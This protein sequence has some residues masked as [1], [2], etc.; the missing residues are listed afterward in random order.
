MAD[1]YPKQLV[2]VADGTVNPPNMADAR[3]VFALTQTSIYSKVT[4]TEWAINDRVCLGRKPAG[5]KIADIAVNTGTSFGSA[6][7]DVGDGT[8]VDK[9]VDGKTVTATDAWVSIGPKAATL[10]DDIGGEEDIWLTVLSAAIVSGT[11]AS[12]RVT[13]T[14]Q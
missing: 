5:W 14:K 10:D 3:E 9:F 2:G 4:G 13:F 6:T 1:R 7:L 12:F 11:V 8:T